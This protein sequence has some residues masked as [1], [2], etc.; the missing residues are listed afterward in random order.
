MA[1]T[2]TLL[3]LPT[4]LLMTIAE[5]MVP[6]D[7]EDMVLTSALFYAL[8]DAHMFRRVCHAFTAAMD[9]LMAADRCSVL[10]DELAAQVDNVGERFDRA[11]Y[12]QWTGRVHHVSY[13]QWL[14]FAQTQ[15]PPVVYSGDSHVPD[16]LVTETTMLPGGGPEEEVYNAYGHYMQR[17][18]A[19]QTLFDSPMSFLC[20]WLLALT[21]ARKQSDILN[22]SYT[23]RVM[24][25][26]VVIGVDQRY[27]HALTSMGNAIRN[28]SRTPTIHWLLAITCTCQYERMRT[29]LLTLRERGAIHRGPIWDYYDEMDRL[30]LVITRARSMLFAHWIDLRTEL[31]PRPKH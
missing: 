3:D 14:Y 1:H 21:P 8:W 2:L 29:A 17:E 15:C 18:Y 10:Y 12:A 30:L 6:S 23:H 24:E 27:V 25:R 9:R 4:E 11:W 20:N 31:T 5:H 19:L 28:D 13:L 22:A 7:I 16:A 26:L